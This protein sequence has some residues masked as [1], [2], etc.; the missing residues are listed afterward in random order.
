MAERREETR[1]NVEVEVNFR[2]AQEFLAAYS[3][4]ISGGGILIRSQQPQPLNQGV[5]LR[6]TLPGVAH[7]FEISGVVV[8]SNPVGGRSSFPAGMGVKFVDLG[9]KDGALIAGF[10]AKASA[11][12]GHG[13]AEQAPA[14]QPAPQ[15]TPSVRPAAPPP[16]SPPRPPAPAAQPARPPATPTRSPAAGQTSPIVRP[17][18]AP[19]ASQAVKPPA[20]G[21]ARPTTPA[22]SAPATQKIP[23]PA[24]TG[25]KKP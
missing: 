5:T 14:R 9:A 21:A 1:A 18:P 6:F 3:K 2:T 22:G 4:N 19:S 15:P 10:V 23:P 8:W 13:A 12:V 7:Q 16:P 17:V 25:P 11:S 20:P 24:G